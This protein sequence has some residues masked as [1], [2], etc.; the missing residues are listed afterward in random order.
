MTNYI[1]EYWQKISSG[2]ILACKRIKQ[3]YKKLV[4]DLNNPKDPYVFDLELANKPI[5]FIET[6]CMQAQGSN[7]GKP[8]KLQLFQKAKI[9]ATFGFV[10]KE[11]RLRQYKESMTIIGRKNGK[12]LPL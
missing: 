1:L 9:Q 2:E 11:T 12:V 7:M 8:L 10:H 6:F 3:Q 5:E 4:D